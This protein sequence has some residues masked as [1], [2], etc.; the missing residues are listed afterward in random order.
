[1]RAKSLALGDRFI[2][3]VES[4][5]ADHPLTLATP[6]EHARRGSHV[7]FL[8]PQGYAVM[9]A[10][11]A[12]GAQVNRLGWTPLHY[13]ASKGRLETARM[14]LGKQAFLLF[15]ALSRRW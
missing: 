1:M 15:P 10:L 6:R 12:R 3:L 4:R 5:C 13:A 14:L 8:H 9:Q 2:A 7:S 11:I